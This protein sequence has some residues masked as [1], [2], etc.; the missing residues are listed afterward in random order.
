[1]LTTDGRKRCQNLNIVRSFDE[2]RDEFIR[3][4]EPRV[5]KQAI[6]Q[7]HDRALK[8][9]RKALRELYNQVLR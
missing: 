8:K 4:G 5:S 2:I 7:C 6:E 3:R 9:L 1:M